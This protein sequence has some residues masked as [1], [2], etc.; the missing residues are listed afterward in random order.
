MDD[1]AEAGPAALLAADALRLPRPPPVVAAPVAAE[2]EAARVRD[3][4]RVGRFG[5]VVGVSSVIGLVLSAWC[6]PQFDATAREIS[7]AGR[8]GVASARPAY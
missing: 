1:E 6:V 3:L 5:G 2:V 8:A 4:L 7:V